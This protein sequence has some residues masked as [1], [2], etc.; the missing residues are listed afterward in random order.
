MT[1]IL[2]QV[3]A[4][5]Y[6]ILPL[7]SGENARLVRFKEPNV[8]YRSA[9]TTNSH[10]LALSKSFSGG[11]SNEI[12]RWNVC[13]ARWIRAKG[14]KVGQNACIDQVIKHPE[15]NEEERLDQQSLL[16][17]RFWY[18]FTDFRKTEGE[19]VHM[20]IVFIHRLKRHAVVHHRAT[21]PFFHQNRRIGWGWKLAVP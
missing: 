16:G 17:I 1:R 13:V 20:Y 12:W 11:K 10:K 8:S 21:V 7:R 14:D 4:Y 19:W 2:V 9:Y 3:V 6:W 18:V 15:M 5:R